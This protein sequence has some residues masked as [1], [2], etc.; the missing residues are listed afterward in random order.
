MELIK[1]A[2]IVGIAISGIT[3]L[4]GAVSSLLSRAV[5]SLERG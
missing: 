4:M 1:K 3:L 5:E 2:I